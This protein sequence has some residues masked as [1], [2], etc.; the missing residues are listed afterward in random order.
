MQTEDLFQNIADAGFKRISDSI[1]LL[2][3]T[4]ECETY[5]EGLIISNRIDRQ[6]FPTDVGSAIL[7][8]YNVHTAS[9]KF[10]DVDT[11]NSVP[12]IKI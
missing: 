4:K 11:W 7:K 1:S 12:G 6:G 9:H 3:G 5:M 10:A 2:W 8:L